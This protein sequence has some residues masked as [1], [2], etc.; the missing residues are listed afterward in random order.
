MSQAFFVF[1]FT[2]K[3]RNPRKE[4]HYSV[5]ETTLALF[6]A[7]FLPSPLKQIGPCKML[8]SLTLK[9]KQSAIRVVSHVTRKMMGVW[10]SRLPVHLSHHLPENKY[11]CDNFVSA[12]YNN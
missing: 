9:D 10:M 7:T 6:L 11:G 2:L 4:N 3:Q 1:L 5:Y 12:Y 8:G